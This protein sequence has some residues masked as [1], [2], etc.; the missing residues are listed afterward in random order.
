VIFWLCLPCS[1]LRVYRHVA[2]AGP[3]SAVTC[4]ATAAAPRVVTT[5]AAEAI[6]RCELAASDSC[7]GCVTPARRAESALH[8]ACDGQRGPC[9]TKT[10]GLCLCCGD[11]GSGAAD[12]GAEGLPAQTVAWSMVVA[13]GHCGLGDDWIEPASGAAMLL[14]KWCSEQVI[15][16]TDASQ[17]CT[18]ASQGHKTD[19]RVVTKTCCV[20]VLTWG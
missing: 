6:Q 17:G 15:P 12:R 10:K 16:L 1:S 7:W 13:A 8:L 3:E 11:L 20:V 18:A 4:C 2:P 19:Q 14:L 9:G 5:D